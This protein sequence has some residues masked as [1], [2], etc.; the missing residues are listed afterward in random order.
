MRCTTRKRA[1]PLSGPIWFF[2]S[3]G[4]PQCML[5]YKAVSSYL[6][7]SPLPRH[8]TA[9][10]YSLWH[11]LSP[12]GGAFP[13]GSRMLYVARTFLHP[14]RVGT[15]IE[16]FALYK[17]T[18]FGLHRYQNDCTDLLG[19]ACGPRFTLIRLQAL[20]TGPVS[21]AIANAGPLAHR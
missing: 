18:L 4:L 19:V 5:P 1:A 10:V 3:W 13:L 7:F 2:N 17:D 6:T 9:A 20:A 21:A 12:T 8:N 11:L 15:A 16:R 14:E